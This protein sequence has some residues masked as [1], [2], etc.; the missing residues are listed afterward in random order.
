MINVDL[1][2]TIVS[3]L[4]SATWSPQGHGELTMPRFNRERRVIELLQGGRAVLLFKSWD[5]PGVLAA[6]RAFA[7][8]LEHPASMTWDTHRQ[9]LLFPILIRDELARDLESFEALFEEYRVGPRSS[10]PRD[11]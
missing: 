4:D 10:L 7:D 11:R 3:I 9:I 2:V 1:I 5:T 8:A 6:G